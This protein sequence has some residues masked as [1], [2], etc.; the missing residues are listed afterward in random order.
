M[1]NKAINRFLAF[2]FVVLARGDG[3]IVVSI[4][5]FQAI[6]PGSIPGHRK[7]TF[8]Y[9]LK[10]RIF[11]RSTKNR[12]WTLTLGGKFDMLVQNPVARSA[13]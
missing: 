10:L 8:F 3:G 2:T 5:A 7:T 11:L 9:L 1:P 13:F 4:V 6:D 12:L